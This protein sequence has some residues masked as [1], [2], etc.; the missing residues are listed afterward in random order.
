MERHFTYADIEAFFIERTA[1]IDKRSGS[2]G[3]HELKSISLLPELSPPT[4]EVHYAA[5]YH[6]GERDEWTNYCDMLVIE[7]RDGDGKPWLNGPMS[8]ELPK[9]CAPRLPKKTPRSSAGSMSG[10][11]HGK[12]G[13][14][15]S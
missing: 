13:G 6:K 15:Q 3:V 1:E 12:P 10:G 9:G 4:W 7:K 14:R 11:K 2:K 5:T 8:E